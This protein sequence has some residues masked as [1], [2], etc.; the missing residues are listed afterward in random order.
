MRYFS[1]IVVALGLLVGC[2]SWG[3]T[4]IDEKPACKCGKKCECKPG[5]DCGCKKPRLE[6]TPV[7]EDLSGIYR[8]T[9]KTG[10]GKDYAGAVT[11]RHLKGGLYI[12]EWATG[13]PTT[14]VG[15]LQ[16]GHLSVSW[17]LGPQVGVT[18][19]KASG[20]RLVGRW[21]VMAEGHVGVGLEVLEWLADLP[22]PKAA[23]E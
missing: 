16:D 21:A 22:V 13:S 9:G 2:V 23:E 1:G 20:K 8:A 4:A 7:V 15:L 19:F 3:A 14:G 11:V 18:H 10:S 17:T 5:A 6:L 12:V